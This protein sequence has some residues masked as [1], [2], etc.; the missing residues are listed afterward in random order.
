MNYLKENLKDKNV[1]LLENKSCKLMTQIILKSML[2]LHALNS[3]KPTKKM[4]AKK[5]FKK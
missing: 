5:I 1:K 4:I 3:H 2:R